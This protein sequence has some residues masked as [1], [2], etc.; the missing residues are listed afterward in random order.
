MTI[1]TR[2][3]FAAAALAFAAPVAPAF[4]H[5]T[6]SYYDQHARDHADH[7][8]FHSDVRRA[9][10]EAHEQGF[11]SEAEHRAYHRALRDLHQEF[12]EDHPG[13]WHDHYSWRI[14]RSWF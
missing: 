1:S 5:D 9:H 4:A 3:F 2:A 10:E 14:W 12:H 8:G 11:D 7:W 13:T 6:E